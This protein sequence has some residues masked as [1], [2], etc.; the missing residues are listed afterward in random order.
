MGD[1]MFPAQCNQQYDIKRLEK[2]VDEIETII[3][4]CGG[5]TV[6]IFIVC[7]IIW[8]VMS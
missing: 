6:F 4:I 7:T 3:V 5:F 2:R 1:E 8:F